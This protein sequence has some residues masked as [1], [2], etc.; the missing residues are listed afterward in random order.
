MKKAIKYL[1]NTTVSKF[2]EFYE[3]IIRHLNFIYFRY[4]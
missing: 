3:L 4:K 1:L 2:A